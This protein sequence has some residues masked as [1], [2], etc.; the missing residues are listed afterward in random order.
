MR[1]SYCNRHLHLLDSK[2]PQRL[3]VPRCRHCHRLTLGPVHKTALALLAVVIL[4]LLIAAL[5][6]H[7]MTK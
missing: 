2:H 1:C 7:L 5:L 3:L 6:P 4:Y